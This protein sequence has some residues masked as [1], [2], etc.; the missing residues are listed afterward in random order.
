MPSTMAAN[1]NDTTL[2]KTQSGI[3][4]LSQMRFLSS[5]GCEIIFMCSVNFWHQPDSNLLFKESMGHVTSQ[6]KWPIFEIDDCTLTI[7][8]LISNI[9]KDEQLTLSIPSYSTQ[10]VGLQPCKQTSVFN[11]LDGNDLHACHGVQSH[12]RINS[13][14]KL[15]SLEYHLALFNKKWELSL[16]DI[17][18]FLSWSQKNH[19]TVRKPSNNPELFN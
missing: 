17:S 9:R 4:Y 11:P 6:W 3:K 10:L 13:N 8:G 14:Y 1:T 19:S 16:I 18:V 12:L 2:L 7:Q 15:T 5:F